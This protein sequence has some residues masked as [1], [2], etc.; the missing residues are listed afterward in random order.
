MSMYSWRRGRCVHIAPLPNRAYL[1]RNCDHI[2][3]DIL[4]M[5]LSGRCP[6]ARTS[7]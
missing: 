2:Q 5:S 1:G 6:W 4:P 3:V 7:G